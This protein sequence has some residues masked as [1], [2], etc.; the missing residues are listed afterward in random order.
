MIYGVGVDIIEIERVRGVLQRKGSRFLNRVY[1]ARERELCS[2]KI[3]PSQELAAYFCAKEAFLKA[4]GTGKSERI[5]WKDVSVD[6]D[7]KG[8]PLIKVDGIVREKLAER[9]ISNIQVSLSH[10]DFYAVA[11]VILEQ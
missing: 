8:K 3:D 10:S 11:V 4:L 9:S 1:T 5:R 2:N 6:K 7:R